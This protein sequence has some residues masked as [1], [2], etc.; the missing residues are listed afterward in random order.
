MC[1]LKVQCQTDTL[2]AY[3]LNTFFQGKVAYIPLPLSTLISPTPPDT[4]DKCIRRK[5]FSFNYMPLN[6]AVKAWSTLLSPTPPNTKD[7]CI[8]RKKSRFQ[9]YALNH[10]VKVW[11]TL[12]SP[13]PPNTKD[14]C[15][16]RKKSV[17]II[18]TQPCCQSLVQPCLLPN[19]IDCLILIEMFTQ[20]INKF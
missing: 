14:K 10:A 3:R 16:R 12:I 11:S 8:R 13:T 9:L 6:R 5:K 4:K 18:C 17:S 19:E 2:Q 7:K 1:L 20:I 15:I